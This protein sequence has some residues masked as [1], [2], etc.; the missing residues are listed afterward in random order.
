MIAVLGGGAMGAALAV[1]WATAG[2]EVALLGTDFDTP[3][4]AA[5]R[6][7]RAHPALGVTL[8]PALTYRSCDEWESVL[9][10]ADVIV[11]AL[12][13]A[14]LRDLV[15]IGARSARADATWVIATKGWQA[16][17]F[18]SP[19]EVVGSIIGSRQRTVS[20]AGPALAAEVVAGAPTAFVFAAHDAE[21]GKRVARSLR[22]NTT[23]T[24]VTDDVVGAETASAYKNVVAIAVGMCEGLSE[25]FAE[26]ALNRT[27]ANGRAAVFAQGM[28]DMVRLVEAKG[29]RAST[30]LGLAG[31]GDLYVTC[32]GG[33]NG[34]FGRLEGDRQ[35]GRG[36]RQHQG[37]AC[38]RLEADDRSPDRTDRR[39]P[40]TRGNRRGGRLSTTA[41][42]VRH[43]AVEQHR[44]TEHLT[45]A[46][47]ELHPPG[48]LPVGV[49]A[50]VAPIR[51]IHRTSI[52]HPCTSRRA[53]DGVRG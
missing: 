53:L 26:S 43:G 24:V 48:H 4:L 47:R 40:P 50:G 36:H 37:R 10:E 51:H 31:A 7:G 8:H 49:L 52:G 44:R 3:V 42:V 30:V 13:S 11:V 22:S 5:V 32:L 23:A 45:L 29:G 20:L 38:P 41:G 39:Y 27:F 14:G 21:L 1:R 35:H 16:D 9:A 17:T 33:R 15:T 25:R 12:S 19:S 34:R 6:N 28:T 18:E 46:V 2:A